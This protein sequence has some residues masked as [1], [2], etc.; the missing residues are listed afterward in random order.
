M[1]QG[2]ILFVLLLFYLERMSI[3]Y[4]EFVVASQVSLF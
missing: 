4:L 3:G 2:E 1:L